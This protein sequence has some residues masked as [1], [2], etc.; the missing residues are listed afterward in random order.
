M[1]PVYG[2]RDDGEWVENTGFVCR[3]IPDDRHGARHQR[4]VVEIPGGQSLLIAHNIDVAKRVPVG[5]GDRVRFR[6]IYEFN[7]RGGIVHWTHRDPHGGDDNGWVRFRER[8]Y[9]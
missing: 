6:G 7:D 5:L 4:F 1:E 2:K 3:I 8:D 9:D